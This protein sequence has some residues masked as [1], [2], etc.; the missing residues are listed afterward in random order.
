MEQHTQSTGRVIKF[1]AWDEVT[2][3]M[4]RPEGHADR[5]RLRV[6]FSGTVFEDGS[7]VNLVLMQFTGLTDKNGKEIFEGDIVQC[8]LVNYVVRYDWLFPKFVL[9][10]NNKSC[11]DFWPSQEE[12]EVIGNIYENPELLK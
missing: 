9:G 2:K 12:Y 10:I 3:E 1:R 5:N 4:L 11:R 8:N 7:P 6:S